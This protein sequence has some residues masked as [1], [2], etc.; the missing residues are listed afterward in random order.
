MDKFE[1]KLLVLPP[2]LVAAKSFRQPPGGDPRD[3]GHGGPADAAA[4]P[5]RSRATRLRY[6]F[7]HEWLP[8]AKPIL[9]TLTLVEAES[10]GMCP[11]AYRPWFNGGMERALLMTLPGIL[12]GAIP[13][14][15]AAIAL[16][17]LPI[18][19]GATTADQPSERARLIVLTDIGNEPDDS[20]S[21]VRLLVH[22]N[23]IEIEGLVATTSRHLPRDPNPRL[24]AERIDAYGK[25]LTNLRRHDPRYPDAEYLGA[26][27]RS[28]SPVYGMTGVGKGRDTEASRLIISA[29]D[30]KDPRPVW[31]AVWG[32]AADLAQALWTV[33]ATRSPREVDRFVANLRVYSISDQDDAGPWA[34]AYFP[35]LFW[36]TSVHG[37]TR[38]NLSTWI[39]I[40][41][42]LSGTDMS[43][44]SKDWLSMNIRS[45]GPL[46]ALYPLPP[47]IM[48]GDTPSFLNLIPTGISATER[49]DW[50]G[51]G[52][53]YE[54]LTNELGLWAST[55]DF[56][57]GTDGKLQ[58]T[59]QA[60]IWRWRSAFQNE[61]AARMHWSVTSDFAQANHAPRP[62]LNGTGG[63]APVEITACPGQPVT[64][65]AAGSSDPDGDAVTYRWFWYREA[66][67]LFAPNLTLSATEGEV[68]QVTI[69]DKANTDQSAPPERYT[70]HVILE[71]TDKGAPALTRYRRAI[72]TVPGGTGPQDSGPCKVVPQP[73]V[74]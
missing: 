50:G 31:I 5:S 29:V 40:S 66:S 56:V 4:P 72:L 34:R 23:D 8:L 38:Y 49:P 48:E 47:Y 53:R 10:K 59:P 68:T 25:V 33:R 55:A 20:E 7:C 14:V 70:L 43:H 12:R 36:V 13:K 52:G 51:W 42:P 73:P 3:I 71:V 11:A 65:S 54:K 61:F 64:L 19:A 57:A 32:G 15:G 9:V 46:G 58:F 63:L 17:C 26:R 62:H 6:R 27:L 24:I 45:K 18:S 41:A 35:K 22:A 2:G 44:V 28:G 69:G 16:A 30:R 39:G 1:R 67:G 37:F 21:M 74:H 60:T